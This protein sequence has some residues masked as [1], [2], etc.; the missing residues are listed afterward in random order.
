MRA[1]VKT[2]RKFVAPLFFV[3]GAAGGNGGIFVDQNQYG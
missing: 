3:R 2:G 1:V